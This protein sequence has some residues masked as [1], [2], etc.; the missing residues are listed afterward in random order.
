MSRL[1]KCY[2]LHKNGD[3]KGCEYNGECIIENNKII[4]DGHGVLE[5]KTVKKGIDNVYKYNG[6]WKNNKNLDLE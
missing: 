2:I 5:C 6:D 4:M 3:Y 1:S